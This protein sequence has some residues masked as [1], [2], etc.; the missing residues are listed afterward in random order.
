[1][2]STILKM[3]TPAKHQAIINSPFN[4]QFL[5][6]MAVAFVTHIILSYSVD[7][8]MGYVVIL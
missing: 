5:F 8:E 3:I 2:N 6:A 1:M 7:H 4:F